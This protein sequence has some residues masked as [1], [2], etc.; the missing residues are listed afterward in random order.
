MTAVANPAG[1]ALRQQPVA[2]RR[3]VQQAQARWAEVQRA[4]VRLAVL[5][6]G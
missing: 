5:A 3:P 1:L 2:L 6:A 4:E